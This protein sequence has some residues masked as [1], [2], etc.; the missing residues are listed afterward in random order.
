MYRIKFLYTDIDGVLSLGSEIN[1]KL[2]EKWGYVHRFN[3]KAVDVYND[4]L[5]KTSAFPIISSDWKS[6]YTLQDLREIFVEFAKIK[7][8]PRDITPEIPGVTVQR[9][10]EFRAKEILQHVAEHN[11]DVWVAIDD[12]DL[13]PWIPKEHFV[14]IPR[15]YEGIKQTGKADELIEKLNVYELEDEYFSNWEDESCGNFVGWRKNYDNFNI[16]VNREN[17][18]IPGFYDLYKVPSNIRSDSPWNEEYWRNSKSGY[19]TLKELKKLVET[20]ERN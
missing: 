3:K 14:F 16:L 17:P 18:A 4:V 5:S 20:Y 13:S 12:L 10:E 19:L 15:W 11:P 1:P 9:L 8:P 6:H 7:I 2:T